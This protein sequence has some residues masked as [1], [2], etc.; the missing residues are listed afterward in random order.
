MDYNELRGKFIEHCSKMDRSAR[1][2]FC[3]KRAKDLNCSESNIDLLSILIDIEWSKEY[4]DK[5]PYDN[6]FNDLRQTKDK[7]LSPL[8]ANRSKPNKRI[9]LFNDTQ[10]HFIWDM[11]K[12]MDR[13]N[14]SFR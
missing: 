6:Y 12:E 5:P 2:L 7:K 11:E 8:L 9:D 3:Y 13:Q 10:K 14:I 4:Q 1:I